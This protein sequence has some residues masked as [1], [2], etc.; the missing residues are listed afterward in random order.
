MSTAKLVPISSFLGTSKNPESESSGGDSGSLESSDPFVVL[1]KGGS[2]PLF[3]GMVINSE[4]D[5]KFSGLTRINGTGGFAL[6]YDNDES[7]ADP[8]WTGSI[9]DNADLY[10]GTLFADEVCTETGYAF[11]PS[12]GP[13]KISYDGSKFAVNISGVDIM[14]EEN[15]ITSIRSSADATTRVKV[16]QISGNGEITADVEGVTRLDL[17]NLSSEMLSPDNLTSVVVENDSAIIDSNGTQII[18]ATPSITTI[19]GGGVNDPT[20]ILRS[21]IINSSLSNTVGNALSFGLTNTTVGYAG[22]EGV[23]YQT[24]IITERVASI[25]RKRVD[26]TSM[27]LYDASSRAR[28]DYGTNNTTLTS[29]NGTSNIV[30]N[31][32]NSTV[33]LAGQRVIDLGTSESIFYAASEFSSLTLGDSSIGFIYEYDGTRRLEARSTY[34][35]VTSPDAAINSSVDDSNFYVQIDTPKRLEVNKF[36]SIFRNPTG[37]NV[38][39]ISST[40]S[41]TISPGI[42]ANNYS[43]FSATPTGVFMSSPDSSSIIEINDSTIYI[44][45]EG[46]KRFEAGGVGDPTIIRGDNTDGITVNTS[47]VEIAYPTTITGNVIANPTAIAVA[48]LD[49]N[50]PTGLT[51]NIA[52]FKVNSVELAY[53]SPTGD[54]HGN[55]LTTD[56]SIDKQSAGTM[57][58]GSTT[59]TQLN[60]GRTTIATNVKGPLICEEDFTTLD[61]PPYFQMEVTNNADLTVIPSINDI[62]TVVFNTGS[63]IDN[64]KNQFSIGKTVNI[65]R[66]TYNSGSRPR[67]FNIGYTITFKSDVISTLQFYLQKYDIPDGLGGGGVDLPIEFTRLLVN[68]TVANNLVTASFQGLIVL[69]PTEWLELKCTSNS[70]SNITVQNCSLYGIGLSR[71]TP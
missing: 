63:L 25:I 69:R 42:G 32:T 53:I 10:L 41:T 60:I 12:F 39:F 23:T 6:F 2:T 45:S 57:T 44:E 31:N 14:R 33:N 40:G 70:V 17:S 64:T 47:S 18:N 54:V 38:M 16:G 34:S 67:V 36:D 27:T 66:I 51:S 15:D 61:G 37:D 8:S 30:I 26:A 1:N 29:G 5:T 65:G 58:I 28:V 19:K 35:R 49:I 4:N 55:S 68:Y 48:S 50:G 59:Q 3:T 22:T 43:A 9:Q 21:G 52:S 46:R 56:G 71:F 20:L 7:P 11:G 24:G 13:N 62:S